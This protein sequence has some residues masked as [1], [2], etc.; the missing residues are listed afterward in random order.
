MEIEF[1]A[2]SKFSNLFIDFINKEP[3]ILN[4]FNTNYDEIFNQYLDNS[5][6]SA[7][8]SARI[9]I[10]KFTMLG[11]ELSEKQK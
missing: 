10:I 1:S 3:K 7:P 9:D 4:R 6:V 8:N 5:I 2:I 11:I